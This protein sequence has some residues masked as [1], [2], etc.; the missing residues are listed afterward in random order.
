MFDSEEFDGK[1]EREQDIY[2]RVKLLGSGSFGKAYLV[3]E[4]KTGDFFVIKQI[5]VS[6]LEASEQEKARK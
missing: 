6:D 1:P 4:I 5:N 2:Q 3:K